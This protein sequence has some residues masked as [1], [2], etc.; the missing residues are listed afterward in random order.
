MDPYKE[1]IP[2]LSDPP[3]LG[4][5]H[6]LT[7]VDKLEFLI[8]VDNS[9]EWFSKLPEGFSHELPQ[10]LP[11][12]PLDPLTKVPLIDFEH[13]CCGAHGLSILLKTTVNGKEHQVLLDA[14]PDGKTI[15]RNIEAMQ[16][17]LNKLD[18]LVLSHW[19]S[20]HSGGIPQVLSLRP[21]HH[22]PLRVDVHP[23]RPIRRGIA[24][25]PT[26]IPIACLNPDPTFDQ[27]KGL[28]GMVFQA[29]SPHEV[30]GMNFD[31]TG[32]EVSGEVERVTGFEKGIPG[33]V[34][35]V[36][37]DG[38]KGWFTDELIMDERYITVDVKGKG[39]VIFSPC[40]HAGICNVIIEAIKRHDRP[41]HMVVGG[42]H[43]VPSHSQPVAETIDFLSNRIHPKPAYILPLHCTGMEARAKLLTEMGERCVCAGVGMK[44]VVMGNDDDE[45]G[46]DELVVK[47]DL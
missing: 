8:L 10:H 41:I 12:A 30:L 7:K 47:V 42:F 33:A 40:S 38:D 2:S 13:Y 19:H 21:P 37:E 45:R 1:P 31:K 15:E 36:D 29:N 17:D 34:R 44:V 3:K 9:I 23:D 46:L 39:L 6:S 26:Y 11:R 5:G 24:P 20:D 18:C 27:I 4:P 43:L 35:W 22:L 14:G 16:V 32:V 25:P 28:N